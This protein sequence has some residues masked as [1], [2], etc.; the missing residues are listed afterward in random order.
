MSPGAIR[1]NYILYIGGA[2]LRPAA[3]SVCS[4][5]PT[6][7]HG[8]KGG[9]AIFAAA[10]QRPRAEMNDRTSQVKFVLAGIIA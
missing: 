9:L 8:I 10:K 4:L 1:N 6:I 5:L 3:S 2:P 7:W